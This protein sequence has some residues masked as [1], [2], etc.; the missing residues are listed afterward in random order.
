MV[1]FVEKPPKGLAP[2]NWIN[3]GTYVLEP[4]VLDRIPERL[5][6]SI[7][8]ETF[9]RMLDEPSRLYAMT[10][11]AYWIDIGTPEKY[12]RAHTDVLR[13]A[14]GGSPAPGAREL[15]P[16]VWVQGAPHIDADARLEAP[17]LIGDRA[18]IAAGARV[19]GSVVGDGAV[20]GPGARLLRSVVHADATLADEAEAIDAVVGA[21]ASLGAGAIASDHTVMGAGATLGAGARAS[22]ARIRRPEPDAEG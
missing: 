15:T 18:V 19:V 4:S 2:T 7:E 10:S 13:A 21:G 11:D 16:G 22:G 1:A 20:V 3:G 6:V 17:T 14:L 8:R 9:P 12:L 5:T